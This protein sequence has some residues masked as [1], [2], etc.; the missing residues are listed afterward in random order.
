MTSIVLSSLAHTWLI[1]VDGTIVVHNGYKKNADTL[2]PGVA[3]FWKKIPSKDVI[4]LLTARE[5]SD[6]HDL[7]EL[8]GREGLRFH[9]IIS[10]LPTGERLLLNDRKPSGLK[11]CFAINVGRDEGLAE[12]EVEINPEL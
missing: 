12:L 4:I 1:D 10:G 9:R 5:E 8:L 2:L 7:T 6:I 11:T 3:E